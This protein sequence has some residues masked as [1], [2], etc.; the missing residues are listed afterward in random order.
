MIKLTKDQQ[1]AVKRVFERGPTTPI[2]TAAEARES[3]CGVPL[4][5]KQFRRRLRPTIGLDGA[6][7]L[8]WAGMF[9]LIERDGYTHS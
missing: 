9:L 1:R 2:V 7:V 5:Y 3:V 8:P 6:V 4:T